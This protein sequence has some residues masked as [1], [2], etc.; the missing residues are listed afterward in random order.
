M[1]NHFSRKPVNSRTA[2]KFFCKPALNVSRIRMRSWSLVTIQ[3]SWDTTP[4]TGAGMST[5]Q[6]EQTLI[7]KLNQS[8]LGSYAQTRMVKF[9]SLVSRRGDAPHR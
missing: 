5:N 6:R 3:A 2:V 7:R 9:E 1:P 8:N 4:T